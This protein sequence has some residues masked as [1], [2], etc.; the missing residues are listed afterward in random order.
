M[1]PSTDLKKRDVTEQRRSASEIKFLIDPALADAIREWARLHMAPDPNAKLGHGDAYETTTL[2]F[3]TSNFDIFHRRGSF[4]RGKYR[5]RRYGASDGVFLERKLRT[6]DLVTKRR[7]FIDMQELDRLTEIEPIEDWAGY[8]FHRRLLARELKPVCQIAYRR[9]ARVLNTSQG[10]SR[11]TIDEDIR[12]ARA[13][14]MVFSSTPHVEVGAEQQILELKFVKEAP[15]IFKRMLSDFSLLP[16]PISKYRMAAFA[17]GYCASGIAE[18]TNGIPHA[19]KGT[20][21][22]V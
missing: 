7:S 12:A 15:G 20:A 16:Q 14:S 4:A 21:S 10:W 19:G 8:W 1:L 6:R 9:T 18:H 3:D 2:Y 13:G 17:L 11:L 5:V 22:S